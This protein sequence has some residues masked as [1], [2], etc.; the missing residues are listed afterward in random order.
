MAVQIVN[1]I[2]APC[3]PACLYGSKRY[4]VDC[5]IEL[6]DDNGKLIDSTPQRVEFENRE[7]ALAYADTIK[8]DCKYQISDLSRLPI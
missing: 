2:V 7:K 5:R 6:L 1:V 8:P 3:Y 4:A